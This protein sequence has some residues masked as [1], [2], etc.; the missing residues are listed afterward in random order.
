LS[1]ALS[2]LFSL[3]LFTNLAMLFGL[4]SHIIYRT[5]H[6][7]KYQAFIK[8][9]RNCTPCKIGAKKT[10]ILVQLITKRA[11]EHLYFALQMFTKA[12]CYSLYFIKVTMKKPFMEKEWLFR[13]CT[14][15]TIKVVPHKH[16]EM[17]F[18]NNKFRK[19]SVNFLLVGT[20]SKSPYMTLRI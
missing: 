8:L 16:N 17:V 11:S 12:C 7:L 9:T 19:P 5:L 3:L 4:L 2:L 20:V 13:M 14:L 1:V 15:D 10:F 6:R 18:E